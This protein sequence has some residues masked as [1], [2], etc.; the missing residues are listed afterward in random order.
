MHAFKWQDERYSQDMADLFETEFN[1]RYADGEFIHEGTI[2]YS[3][4][5]FFK[6]SPQ[7]ETA[8]STFL[9]VRKPIRP[10]SFLVLPTQT[11]RMRRFLINLRERSPLDARNLVILNGDA[12]SFH[13]VYRDR[14]VIWRILD[15]PYSLV[16]FSHRNPIDHAAGFDWTPKDRPAGDGAF[17]QSTT[18][19]T[20]DLLLYRDLFE[21]ILYA[22]FDHDQLLSDPLE[23]RK[24]LQATCWHQP[25]QAKNP[26]RARVCNPLLHTLDPQPP[27]FFDAAGNRQSRTGEH[28]VW[29]KPNFTEDRVDKTSK[30]SVWALQP[31]TNGDSWRFVEA[32][33]RE[34]VSP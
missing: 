8:V 28:I 2:P 1:R 22:A 4:G 30:I 9:T 26:E 12:I 11:V 18:T 17:P 10:H 13:S 3:V 14:D 27:P 19:G 23:V 32:Y 21:A 16:F 6:P 31:H 29:V 15:L 7:E 33:P 24:R 20:H 5:G 25:P 34:D